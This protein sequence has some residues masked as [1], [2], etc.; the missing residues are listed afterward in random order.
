MHSH[1]DTDV[2]L[3]NPWGFEMLD[4]PSCL[5]TCWAHNLSFHASFIYIL[6]YDLIWQRT[7]HVFLESEAMKFMST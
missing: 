5:D 2:G 7:A 4:C 1:M 6:S 3:K